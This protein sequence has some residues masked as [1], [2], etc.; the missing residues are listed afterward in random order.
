MGIKGL[1]D[2]RGGWA[3]ITVH[4]EVREVQ[5]RAAAILAGTRD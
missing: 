4:H 2:E 5:E 1:E 3:C